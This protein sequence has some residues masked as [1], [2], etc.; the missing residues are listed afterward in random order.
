V[1]EAV[2]GEAENSAMTLPIA[3]LTTEDRQRI[4]RL[5][6]VYSL[7]CECGGGPEQAT[8]TTIAF[9]LVEATKQLKR[10]ADE[11]EGLFP[12]DFDPENMRLKP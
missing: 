6:S 4:S 7:V 10:L 9:A 5:C 2:E 12:E 3:K 11:A 8:A 1:P